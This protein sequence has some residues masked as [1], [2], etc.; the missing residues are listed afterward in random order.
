MIAPLK[1]SSVVRSTESVH[2]KFLKLL[3]GIQQQAAFAF[4]SISAEARGELTEEVI[5][6]AYCAFIQLVRRG[7]SIL[8]YS[9]PLAQFA[10]RQVRAGRRVGGRLNVHDILSPCAQGS[11]SD[12]RAARSA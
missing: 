3:P 4:R 2:E 7:K 11:Y 9:T 8:A 12:H 10:I 5:A 6:N 1:T